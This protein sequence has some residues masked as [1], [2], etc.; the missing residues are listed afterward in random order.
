MKI[1][2]ANIGLLACSFIS[3]DVKNS[4]L[5]YKGMERV[6]CSLG[7]CITSLSKSSPSSPETEPR[8]EIQLIYCSEVLIKDLIN[9]NHPS[10]PQ[11]ERRTTKE[12]WEELP[13]NVYSIL[14]I[15][16]PIHSG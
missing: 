12:E 13:N 9:S 5:D 15:S 16:W 10:H 3:P 1:S 6:T 14:A 11:K 4:P 8:H 2:E 7:H